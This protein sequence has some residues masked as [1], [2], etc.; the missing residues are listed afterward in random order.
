MLLKKSY[1][2]LILIVCMLVACGKKQPD[3]AT[4][5]N[6]SDNSTAQSAHAGTPTSAPANTPA[7]A[8][9]PAP[10]P[11]PPPPPAPPPKPIIIPSGI[12]V[13]VRLQQALS[14]KTN[15]QGDPFNATLAEPVTVDGRHIK[16]DVLKVGQ[17]LILR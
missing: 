7:P 10:E 3:N 17:R 14:S 2:T 12:V 8:P 1:A 6:P 11:P 16:R 4:S 15:I 13:T 5:Q 9:V